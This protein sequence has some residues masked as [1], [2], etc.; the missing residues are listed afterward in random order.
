MQKNDNATMATST[1]TAA[2]APMPA[3]AP[4]E[5]VGPDP[6]EIVPFPG[7]ELLMA[8]STVQSLAVL[9]QNVRRDLS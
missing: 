8:E 9:S 2:P 6:F 5:R 1:T 3:F 4:A 7:V